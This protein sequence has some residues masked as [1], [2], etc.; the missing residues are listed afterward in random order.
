MLTQASQP[1]STAGAAGAAEGV[2]HR[3]AVNLTCTPLT[4]E[5]DDEILLSPVSRRQWQVT[6]PSRLKHGSPLGHCYT[7]PSRQI[8]CRTAVLAHTHRGPLLC[9]KPDMF[10]ATV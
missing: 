1:A 7:P 8:Q 6:V 2:A 3:R 10:A 9:Y 4:G 5:G